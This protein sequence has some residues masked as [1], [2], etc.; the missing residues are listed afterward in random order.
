MD[1]GHR[2]YQ[3][4]RSLVDILRHRADHQPEQTA[5]LFLPDGEVEGASLTYRGLDE[6]AR[7]VAAHLQ[8]LAPP[9]GQVLLFY[10]PGLEFIAGFLGYLYA[11][12][13]A[14]PL[15]P[16]RRVQ[17]MARF[18]AIV[19]D[20]QAPLALTTSDQLDAL[21]RWA[22]QEPGL[23]TLQWVATDALPSSGADAW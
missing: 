16:P 20:S 18:R 17:S 10:P 19:A 6:R 22:S 9:M 8:A 12:V 3:A 4:S 13:A 15:A 1:Q 11:G 23:A 2:L 7:A 14:V 21:A 5:F